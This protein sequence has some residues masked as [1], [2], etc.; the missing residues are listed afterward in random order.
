MDGALRVLAALVSSKQPEVRHDL[1]Q[2]RQPFGAAA[3]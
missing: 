3:A 1:V 2:A